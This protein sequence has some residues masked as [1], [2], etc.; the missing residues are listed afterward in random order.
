MTTMLAQTLKT[1]VQILLSVAVT[2]LCLF[3][4]AGRI[5]W[6][7]AWMLLDLNV[8]AGV[9]TTALLSRDPALDAERRNTKAGRNWD[10][11]VLQQFVKNACI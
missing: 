9:T 3:V 8:C 10:K 11:R 5:N 2:A 6:P 7:N 4:S 1:S